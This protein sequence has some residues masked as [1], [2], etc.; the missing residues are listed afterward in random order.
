MRKSW[1]V[2]QII[3]RANSFNNKTEQQPGHEIQIWIFQTEKEMGIWKGKKANHSENDSILRRKSETDSLVKEFNAHAI[4]NSVIQNCSPFKFN[5]L[6][7][8][9]NLENLENISTIS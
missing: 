2:I 5:D 3:H 9:E 7:I 1:H 8:D 4:G 6:H